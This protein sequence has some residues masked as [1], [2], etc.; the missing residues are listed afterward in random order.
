MR[1]CSSLHL[2]RR[3]QEVQEEEQEGMQIVVVIRTREEEP[4]P[5]GVLLVGVPGVGVEAQIMYLLHMS[6]QTFYKMEPII[7][8]FTRDQGE[9]V[10]SVAT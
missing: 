3:Q 1:Q 6:G 9:S 2:A 10:M 8:H 5:G 7:A 4:A